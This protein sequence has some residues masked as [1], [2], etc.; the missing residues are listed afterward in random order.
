MGIVRPIRPTGHQQVTAA[1]HPLLQRLHLLGPQRRQGKVAQGDEVDR[2]Q[3]I[4]SCREL[5]EV[6]IHHPRFAGRHAR[7]GIQRRLIGEHEDEPVGTAERA[8]IDLS[9]IDRY[10][11]LI[12]QTN[13]QRVSET[14]KHDDEGVAFA[15]LSRQVNGLAQRCGVR[16]GIA[17]T[18]CGQL[19]CQE[20]SQRG[21]IVA[22]GHGDW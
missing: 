10:P 1:R 11:R 17:F 22:D 15:G 20:P 3:G 7:Q 2:I 21:A 16:L 5:V 14:T 18:D 6:L 4:P 13:D 12:G 9:G 8:E 19:E